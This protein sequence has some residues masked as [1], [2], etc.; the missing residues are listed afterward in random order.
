MQPQDKPPQSPPQAPRRPPLLSYL[1]PRRG[2]WGLALLIDINIA[3]YLAMVVAG[4]GVMEFSARDLVAWGGNYGASLE[5][6]DAYRLV[7]STFVHAGLLHIATNMWGLLLG[8]LFLAPVAR[9]AR[10]IFCYLFC[11]IAGSIASA[12]THPNVVSVGASGAIFGLF[13]MLFVLA[14]LGDRR[15]VEVRRSLFAN[16]VFIIVANLALGFT[17]PGI[18]VSAH[19]GGL[20]A[21]CVLG[22]V[23]YLTG[24]RAA[25]A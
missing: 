5:G 15:F 7:T 18:D 22:L 23:F 17:I 11:G 3:V 16:A 19:I 24:G 12:L 20:V 25:R 6:I 14:G 2:F 9:N 4:L 10:L 8:G 1:I 21:G 13:G